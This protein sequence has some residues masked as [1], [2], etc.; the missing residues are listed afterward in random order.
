MLTFLFLACGQPAAGEPPPAPPV[1]APVAAPVAPPPV[2]AP[3]APPAAACSVVGTWSGTFPAGPQPWNGKPISGTFGADGKFEAMTPMGT[4]AVSYSEAD[5]MLTLTNSTTTGP[6]A[7]K[8]ED[9]GTYKIAYGADCAT[10]A[11]TLVS[12]SCA[13]RTKGMD[14]VTY[15][16]K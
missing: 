11:F 6:G 3:E 15:S 8:P 2:A 13:G 10:V 16:R 4:R 14:G 7:C 5:G 1:A 9:T 12:D